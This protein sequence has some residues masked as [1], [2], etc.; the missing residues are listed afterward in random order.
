[1]SDTSERRLQRILNAQGFYTV[2]TPGS[3]TGLTDPDTDTRHDHP[4]VVAIRDRSGPGGDVLVVEDKHTAD[5]PVYIDP[6]QYDALTAVARAAGGYPVFAVQV[7]NTTYPHD[8]HVLPVDDR[9]DTGNYVLRDDG[10]QVDLQTLLQPGQ[11]P[12]AAP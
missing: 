10:E 3:G 12:V 11:R 9:T 1:M 5:Y 2:R 8:F 4:D 7:K 6:D